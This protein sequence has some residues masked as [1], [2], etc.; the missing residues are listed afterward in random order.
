MR[1]RTLSLTIALLILAMASACGDDDESPSGSPTS[2]ATATPATTLLPT[3]SP[4]LF[5]TPSRELPPADHAAIG[6]FDVLSFLEQNLNGGE[7]KPVECTSFD[8]VQGIIDC[9]AQGYGTIAVDPIPEAT[10]ELLCRALLNPQ[11]AFFGASCAGMLVSGS[12]AYFY[13]I[14][15]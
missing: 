15:S 14:Q 13:S 3:A 1:I 7:L 11:D 8:A 2:D 9:T 10:G 5:L 12:G 4:P 6:V